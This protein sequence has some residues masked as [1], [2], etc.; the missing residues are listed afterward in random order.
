MIKATRIIFHRAEGTRHDTGDH[1][2]VGDHLW[3][4]VERHIFGASFSAP[5][6]GG[7]D[8]CDVTI[9][10][11]DGWGYRTRYDMV[12]ARHVWGEWAFY[13]G[14]RIPPHLTRE[15]W[16]RFVADMAITPGDWAV[17]LARYQIGKEPIGAVI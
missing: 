3:H 17:R 1:E 11:A 12:H 15:Q 14:T 8:K 13:A 16:E 4:D 5:A 10:F 7:Y 2:F 9:T 6:Q